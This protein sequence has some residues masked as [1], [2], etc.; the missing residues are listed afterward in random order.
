MIWQ[1]GT[2]QF[3]CPGKERRRPEMRPVVMGILNVTPDSFSDGGRLNGAQEAVDAALRLL[4]EGA[5]IIDI[6]GESTRPGA[7]GVSTEEELRRTI[8]VIERLRAA[9]PDA[10]ISIDTRKAE[11]AREALRAGACIVNDVNGLRDPKMPELLA[12]TGAGCVIMHMLGEPGTMQREPRYDDV[13]GEILDFLLQ[14]AKV[15]MDAGVAQDRI[16]IDPGIGFGKTLEHNLELIRR[17]DVFAESGYP[18]LIG[19]SRKSFI[20]MALGLE[21][22]QRLEATLAANVA[23]L[24]RGASI[25]RVHDV[26]AARRALDMAALLISS[27][28]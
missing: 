2:H 24:L 26:A 8:P 28:E 12:E 11:V 19:A 3:E 5:D 22:D 15:A 6:G 1:C 18:L 27:T 25:F 20:G 9:R 16:A 14:R 13:V 17:A 23:A 7:A 10:P 21:V 4:E